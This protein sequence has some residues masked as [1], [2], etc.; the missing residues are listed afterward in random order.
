VAKPEWG[1]KR[2]C[3]KCGTRFYDLQ[4]ADPV[5]CIDCGHDWLPEAILKSKQSMPIAAA[6]KAK[7]ESEA[8][9]D[10]EDDDLD[11]GDDDEDI[12]LDDDDADVTVEDD[13]EGEDVSAVVGTPIKD[14][15]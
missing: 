11:L 6:K 12:E 3:P 10:D 14:E 2:T 15:D 5:T 8:D 13:D 4:K 7:P 1:V 9:T